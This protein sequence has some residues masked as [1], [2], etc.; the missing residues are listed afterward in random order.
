[1]DQILHSRQSSKS[2]ISYKWTVWLDTNLGV[3]QGSVLGP[4]LFSLYI[5]DLPNF[6]NSPLTNNN[7]KHIKH[8][9]YADDLQ[10]YIPTTTDKVTEDIAHLEAA[11]Q[12]VA[13]WAGSSVLRLS[14]GKTQAIIFGSSHNI[15]NV[16]EMQLSGIEMEGGV[17]VPFADTVKNLGVI[18]DS[19]LT[20]KNHV[21]YVIKRVNR[22]LFG[23]KFFRSST[24]EFLRK[25]LANALV[26]P[27][28]DYCSIVFL[29]VTKDLKGARHLFF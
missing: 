8:I 12:T 17:F 29:D 18:M 14:V 2:C 4:L 6:L 16:K 7:N 21:E 28:I 3:P 24:T 11:A 20:W 10:I 15:N 26:F 1:M 23:L 13:A 19:K 22:A 9:L 25:R 27:Y 5:N